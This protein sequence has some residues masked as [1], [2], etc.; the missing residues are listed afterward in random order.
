[1]AIP[2]SS[3]VAFD[4]AGFSGL[5]LAA[6]REDPEAVREAAQQFE[7]LLVQ[8]MLKHMRAASQ[9]EL[10]GSSQMDSYYEMFD[11]QVALDMARKGGFGLAD[12][13]VRQLESAARQAP[14]EAPGRDITPEPSQGL[15]K[16]LSK[17]LSGAG[18]AQEIL[19]P[20]AIPLKARSGASE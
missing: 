4:A 1:M 10:F 7:A 11:Q 20:A 6:Q 16:G 8:N 18:A 12:V 5:K 3:G 2:G 9:D 14:V 13:L 19:S 17:V 15:S